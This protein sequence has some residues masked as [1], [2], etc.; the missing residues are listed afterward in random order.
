M[1]SQE[2]VPASSRFW[3][4]KKIELTENTKKNT[5]KKAFTLDAEMLFA[6]Y[7]LEGEDAVNAAR[8]NGV[9][10]EQLVS[11]PNTY[12]YLA[13]SA[14]TDL[15]ANT[16]K[17]SR[18]QAVRNLEKIGYTNIFEANTRS[19]LTPD[20]V[21]DESSETPSAPQPE[22]EQET[23][24]QY[25]RR[26][27]PVEQ[28]VYEQPAETQEQSGPS[29]RMSLSGAAKFIPNVVRQNLPQRGP[30]T[31]APARMS[32]T[33]Q[34]YVRPRSNLPSPRIAQSQR[35]AQQP[36]RIAPQ[37]P[38]QPR[39]LLNASMAAKLGGHVNPVQQ[40]T[41]PERIAPRPRFGLGV[42]RQ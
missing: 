17:E 26:Q 4:G 15:E 18:S 38:Q 8:Q 20:P 29:T 14:I 10:E 24:S 39:P 25:V 28:P 33:P 36:Q 9:T 1:A 32:P 37:Q 30:N 16:S 2:A 40:R 13:M 31:M 6:Q 41:A 12:S 7:N 3:D 11:N 22:P 19:F 21:E 35:V 23:R 27:R 34:A 5:M 42:K